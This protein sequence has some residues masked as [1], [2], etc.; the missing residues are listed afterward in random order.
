MTMEKHASMSLGQY[1]KFLRKQKK[2]TQIEMSRHSGLSKSYISF[3][4]SDL[5]HPSREV[6]LKIARILSLTATSGDALLIKAGYAPL[7]AQDKQSSTKSEP[8]DFPQQFSLLL[9]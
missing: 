4:E 2:M 7:H 1:L 3:L 6:V 5:R 8:Q 9:A